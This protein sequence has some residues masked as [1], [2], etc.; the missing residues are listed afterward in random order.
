MAI[1]MN[2]ASSKVGAKA[3]AKSVRGARLVA[4][5][6]QP[7][8]P[9][10]A[11]TAAADASMLARAGLPPTTTPYDDYKFAPIREAEVSA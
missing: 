2:L 6:A 10:S 7:M 5:V 8:S 9:S 3:S 1:K 4:R 11:A